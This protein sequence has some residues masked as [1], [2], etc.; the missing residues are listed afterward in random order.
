[1]GG[2]LRLQWRIFSLM[3]RA[4]ENV[5]CMMGLEKGILECLLVFPGIGE[6]LRQMCILRKT[7]IISRY[8]E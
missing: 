2:S 8:K 3:I 7:L 1:M 6:S 4:G 5:S